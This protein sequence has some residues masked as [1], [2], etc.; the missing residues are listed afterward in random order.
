MQ[1]PVWS[2]VSFCHPSHFLE[3]LDPYWGPEF[4]NITPKA[5]AQPRS[6]PPHRQMPSQDSLGHHLPLPMPVGA[7]T[8]GVPEFVFIFGSFF[9]TEREHRSDFPGERQKTG[10]Q[11]EAAATGLGRSSSTWP[12]AFGDLSQP[13]L[14]PGLSWWPAE[15]TG[16]GAS[17]ACCLR[18]VLLSWTRPLLLPWQSPSVTSGLGT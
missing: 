7:A 2:P 4:S 9:C 8:S 10:N 6:C 3:A 14:S 12:P 18:S 15:G 17:A 16:Q 11:E 13:P 5:L 1:S